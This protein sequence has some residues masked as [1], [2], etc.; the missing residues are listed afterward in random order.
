M[1]SKIWGLGLV[2]RL[3]YT[4]KRVGCLYFLVVDQFGSY[5]LPNPKLT[6]ISAN[7]LAVDVG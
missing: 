6:Q 4:K 5:L 3:L 7:A 2:Y 1:G